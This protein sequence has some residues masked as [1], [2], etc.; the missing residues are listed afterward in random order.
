M[1]PSNVLLVIYLAVVG[2]QIPLSLHAGESTRSDSSVT[3]DPSLSEEDDRYLNDQ[4][5]ALLEEFNAV[6][7]EYPPQ[8][9]EPLVRRAA[10]LTLDGVFHDVYAPFRPPVQEFL[11]SRIDRAIESM[12]LTSVEEGA[13]IWKLY[14]DGFIVRTRSVTIAFDL[15]TARGV[16]DGPGYS[17]EAVDRIVRQCDALF[18]SHRHGDHADVR[19]AQE[20]ID[21]G[22]PVLAPETAFSKEHIHERVTH[23]RSIPHKVQEVSIKGNQHLRVVAY[24]GH[25]GKDIENIV[26]LVTTPEGLTFV[27][28]GD[29]FLSEDFAWIDSVSQY[30]QVDVL[31][32][33]CWTLDLSR[34]A[35]GMQPKLVIPGHENELGHTIGRRVPIWV[36]YRRKTGDMFG[37]WQ[38]IERHVKSDEPAPGSGYPQP[39]LVMTWGEWYHYKRQ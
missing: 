36:D 23:L 6:A 9:P 32:P 7:A 1:K 13:V 30:H 16:G 11:L 10:L 4:A 28:T 19:F 20:F 15:Y 38:W 12:E 35:D 22:K 31:F 26:W 3:I 8:L 5:Q 39:L 34:M 17:E 37:Y 21:T 25:Q 14:N 2:V 33:Q 29:Q 24:P 18:V 27:Q